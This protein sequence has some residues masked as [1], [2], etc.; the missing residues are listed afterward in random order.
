MQRALLRSNKLIHSH[1]TSR[2]QGNG[3]CCTQACDSNLTLDYHVIPKATCCKQES[4]P[5]HIQSTMEIGH[6]GTT[7]VDSLIHNAVMLRCT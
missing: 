5:W 7:H 4:K 3:G 6:P 2:P 1:T